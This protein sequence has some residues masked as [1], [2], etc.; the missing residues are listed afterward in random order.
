[1][2]TPLLPAKWNMRGIERE[3]LRAFLVAVAVLAIVASPLSAQDPAQERS[4]ALVLPRI[5]GKVTLD[6][7]SNEPTWQGIKPLPVVVYTPN[8]GAEP[9]ERTEILVAYDDDYIYLA[10]RL[11]DREPDKIQ[12][13]SKKRDDMKLSNDWLGIVL[14]TFRDHENALSFFTTPAGLRLDMAVFND[15]EGD[16]PVNENW[17]TFWDVKTVRNAEGWFVEMRIPLSSLRFQV[18][19]GRVHMG[20]TVWRYIARKAE[21]II[22]PFIPDKW[23]FWGSFKPSQTRD[24]VLEGVTSHKPFYVAPYVL[25][26]YGR[27]YELNAGETAYDAEDKFVREAGLDVK[28]GLTNNLTLDLTVNTDFAQ[29]E[30]DDM[31]VNL[32]RFSLFYPEKRPFFQERASVFDFNFG[33]QT[34]LFYSRRIGIS[35]GEL[36]RIYGG[37]RLIG[38]VGGWDL[39]LLD[40]QT[41]PLKVQ[42]LP[43]ENFGVLRVRR[44]VFNRNSW[45]GGMLTSRVGLDGTFN[46]AY[47][48]DGIVNLFGDDY[49]SWNW[50][51]TFATGADNRVLSLDPAKFR[52]NWQRRTLEGLAYNLD[53]SRAG[54][55]Y[56]PGL[57][58]EFREDYTR[59]GNQILYGWMP[60]EKSWLQRHSVFIQGSYYLRNAEGEAESYM[61]GPG[62]QFTAK[63]SLYVAVYPNFC[64]ENVLE[65]FSLS[66]KAVIPAGRYRFFDLNLKFNTPLKSSPYLEGVID[67]GSFYDGH[68]ISAG[69]APRWDVS[70]SLEIGGFYEFDRATFPARGQEFTAHIGRLKVLVMLSTKF[71]IAGFIQYSSADKEVTANV[72]LH[73]NPRE[74]ND[75]YIVYND[76]ANTDRFDSI[77]MLPRSV[78]RTLLVKYTYTFN[79]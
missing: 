46:T 78:G 44:Q 75:F 1:M 29:V 67:V 60:G 26:G 47:G 54:S 34:S 36:V 45:M 4:V 63:S 14:D 72:R 57:G 8:S 40:M 24:I 30:A 48:L 65:D 12:A 21:T 2:G 56:D 31:Q 13:T 74:G 41:A 19:D 38:R 61:I 35:E 7:L 22:S 32:T 50:A 73:Y 11:Y 68:R 51:Q 33:D 10:G 69:L 77:P 66:D 59:F 15:G 28:Y 79:F 53:V 6:G 20:M 52:I 49:L 64:Y 55:D 39:A 43:S 27:S 9:S 23:G 16:F 42:D 17:N 71:S 76:G 3:M 5:Q 70:S 58:F 62:Y 25:G 37:A 18:V